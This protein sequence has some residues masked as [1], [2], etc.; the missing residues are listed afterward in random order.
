MFST[1]IMSRLGRILETSEVCTYSPVIA[2]L[3]AALKVEF[4]VNLDE[5]FI[6]MCSRASELMA[7]S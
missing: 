2:I 6:I 4:K 7:A 1:T 3:N 5:G